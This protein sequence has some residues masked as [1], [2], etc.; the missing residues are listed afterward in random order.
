MTQERVK[1]LMKEISQKVTR[2]NIQVI[3][4]LDGMQQHVPFDEIEFN[5]EKLQLQFYYDFA[6]LG[7]NTPDAVITAKYIEDI[8]AKGEDEFLW[9]CCINISTSS[10]DVYIYAC[11]NEPLSLG[12]N[13]DQD[14][15]ISL[16]ILIEKLVAHDTWIQILVN[17]GDV[18]DSLDFNVQIADAYFTK[19]DDI[20]T[21][22]CFYNGN[23]PPIRIENGKPIYHISNGTSLFVHKAR[24]ER[25]EE[26][27]VEEYQDMFEMP[28]KAIYNVYMEPYADGRAE[29]VTIGLM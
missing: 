3:S 27:P 18:V 4:K 21:A 15:N 6:N 26:L 25:I 17:S 24:I 23:Q 14:E 16:D 2:G 28:S 13:P 5:E 7:E 20:E 10:S 1:D 22:I 19:A 12:D 11:T 29:V 9:N 8:S